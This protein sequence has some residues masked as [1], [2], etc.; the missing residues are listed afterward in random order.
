[1]LELRPCCEAR[2][3]A[4]PPNVIDARICPCECTC[5]ARYVERLLGNVCPNCGGGLTPRP[6]W[7]AADYGQ[8]TGLAHHPASRARAVKPIDS[9]R[10]ARLRYRLERVPAEQR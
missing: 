5:C 10:K 2:D 9:A 1:M 4:L 8:G 6:I 3:R 7:C